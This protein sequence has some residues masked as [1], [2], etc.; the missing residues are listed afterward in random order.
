MTTAN[1]D[2]RYDLERNG[3]VETVG[4]FDQVRFVWRSAKTWR[5]D[6]TS[7]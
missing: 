3:V 7:N 5:Q 6:M 2:F 4:C 1:L